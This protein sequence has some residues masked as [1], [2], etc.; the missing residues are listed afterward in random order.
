MRKCRQRPSENISPQLRDKIEEALDKKEQIF[1]LYNRRGFATY[2]QCRECGDALKC[3]QCSTTLTFH[4]NQQILLCHICGYTRKQPDRCPACQPDNAGIENSLELRGAG[5]EK[6]S[7]ELQELFPTA[8]ILRMDRDSVR[9]FTDYSRILN[10]IRNHTADILIGTQMI[11]KGHDLPNVTLVG[12]IDADVG[13]HRPDFRSAEKTF[14][15]LLQV[16]GRCGRA[17]KPGTVIFQTRSPEHNSIRFAMTGDYL[18][19]ANAELSQ[20]KQLNYPPFC[21]LLRIIISSVN[22]E[23]GAGL[24][25]RLGE[26]IRELAV[27]EK[28]PV[29]ILGPAIAP[30]SKIRNHFR[31]HLLC[32]SGSSQALGQI[33]QAVR[34]V[35]IPARVRVGIDLD[36]QDLL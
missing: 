9:K 16:A 14:Q 7:E 21:R 22:S 33:L 11:A 35:R 10:A 25:D 26:K 24:A 32:K 28:L 34:S 4:K 13:L 1:I 27:R 12:V 19:F 17:D 20:R 3:R 30:L 29:N 5:T 15:L 8:R 6:I 2:L 31:F 23:S 36:P 18:G